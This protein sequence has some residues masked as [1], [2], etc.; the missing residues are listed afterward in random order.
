MKMRLKPLADQTMVITGASS[1]IG[2]VTARKA[3]RKGARL[4]LAARSEDDLSLL[5]D[6]ICCNGGQ[7]IAVQA[8]VGS[9]TDVRHIAAEAIRAFGGFDTWVNNAGVSVYGR[10]L[11]VPIPDMRRV[12]ETNVWGVVYGSRVA[13][14]HLRLRGGALINLGRELSDK[15]APLQAIYSASKHAVKG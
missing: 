15:A 8:D 3:A 11:D 1:G 5:V 2:L 4:V 6:E 9:E 14:E 10:A 13:C 12:F 7:A